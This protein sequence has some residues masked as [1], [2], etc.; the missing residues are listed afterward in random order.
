M[1]ECNQNCDQGRTCD[2]CDNRVPLRGIVNGCLLS[3]PI[4]LLIAVIVWLVVTYFPRF[5]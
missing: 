2:C 4:W 1:P 3:L 5:W